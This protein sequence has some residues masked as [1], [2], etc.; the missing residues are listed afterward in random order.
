MIINSWIAHIPASSIPPSIDSVPYA[1]RAVPTGN[2]MKMNMNA[3]NI[4]T[5]FNFEPVR[6]I[7]M[8]MLV[9]SSLLIAPYWIKV[10]VTCV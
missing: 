7:Q 3:A 2:M 5:V 10:L 9:A 8:R 1:T 6:L 4:E